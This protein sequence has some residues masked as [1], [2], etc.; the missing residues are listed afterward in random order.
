MG[1]TDKIKQQKEQLETQTI[2]HRLFKE[3]VA[4]LTPMTVLCNLW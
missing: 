4:G 3:D 2:I 1:N